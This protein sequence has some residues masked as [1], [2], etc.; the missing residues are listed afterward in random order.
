MHVRDIDRMDNNPESKVKF[1]SEELYKAF[2]SVRSYIRHEDNLINNRLTWLL[3]AQGLIFNAYSGVLKNT[4]ELSL[5]LAQSKKAVL[6]LQLQ[7]LQRFS[8]TLEIIG[9]LIG[10]IGL[11][12]VVA[13]T[14]SIRSL[15]NS[16]QDLAEKHQADMDKDILLSMNK[17]M[18]A[19]WLDV[20]G[21]GDA[22]AKPLGFIAP[23]GIPLIVCG[24]WIYLL[25]SA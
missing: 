15:E 12:G 2:E 14:L 6:V 18:S 1:T 7:S 16:F 17:R 11:M 8:L 3:I 13:A 19:K 10:C 5:A 22:I 20:T 24:A 21:G 9:F 4:T 23:I 25:C